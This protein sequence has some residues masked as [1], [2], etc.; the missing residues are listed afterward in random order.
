MVEII[1]IGWRN[2]ADTATLSGGSWASTLPLTDG[3]GK[4]AAVVK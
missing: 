3:A 1:Q 2:Y 4:D